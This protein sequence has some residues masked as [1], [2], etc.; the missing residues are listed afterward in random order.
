[1]KRNI[2]EVGKLRRIIKEETEFNP[3]MFGDSETKEINREAYR[4]MK[5]QT[6]DYNGGLTSGLTKKKREDSVGQAF[7]S[8][9][10]GMS[11][12]EVQNPSKPFAEKVEAQMD[13]YDSAEA[14]KLHKDEEPGN[15]TKSD[16]AITK[17]AK[18]HAKDA[19]DGRSKATKI[20]LTGRELNAQ[21]VDKLHNTMFDEHKKMKRLTFK[22]RFISENHMVSL[23][24]DHYK[25]E[26]NK[27]AMKDNAGTEYLVEWKEEGP[28]VTKKVN[29]TEAHKEFD[30]IK[31]LWGYKSSESTQQSSSVNESKDGFNKTLARSRELMK[32]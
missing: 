29:L 10:K 6:E 18:K 5:K 31:Q 27:F 11:D 3:V 12:I 21:D 26:G 19:A 4:D 28:N 16:G 7:R 13:G 22:Q 17:A 30:R 24:P 25:T 15:F 2:I 32:G 23:I 8:P 9:N 1:M 20:G 14:K